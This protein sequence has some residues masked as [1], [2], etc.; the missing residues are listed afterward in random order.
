M[1][2]LFR[3]NL[4]SQQFFAND[5]I[6]LNKAVKYVEEF[7]N[8]DYFDSFVLGFSFTDQD[9]SLVKHFHYTTFTNVEVLAIILSGSETLTPE[10]DNEAD[11]K[12]ELDTSWT[13]NVIG[14]TNI[15]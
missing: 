6:K 3:V 10:V 9:D 4:E 15:S 5:L 2:K 1:K 14:Y 8:S 13:R 11:I 7:I 12:I